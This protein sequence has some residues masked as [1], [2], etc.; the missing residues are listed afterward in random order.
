L[1]AV[2]ALGAF[3]FLLF[4]SC[5]AEPSRSF[6]RAAA[7]AEDQLSAIVRPWIGAP[8]R[9]GGRSTSG[10]DCSGFTQAVIEEAFGVE[11]PRTSRDQARTGFSVSRDELRPGDLVLFDLRKNKRGIDHVGLYLGSGRFAHASRPRGV[12]VDRLDDDYFRT[13][14]RGARRIVSLGA[15]EQP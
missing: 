5:A 13:G 8:Y 3:G 1:A 9:L 2:R 15:N 12:V 14:Y 6:E 10:T 11:V 7:P 4:V